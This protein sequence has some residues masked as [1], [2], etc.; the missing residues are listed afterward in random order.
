MAH[1]C[2]GGNG[3]SDFAEAGIFFEAGRFLTMVQQTA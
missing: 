2:E 3:C 1:V